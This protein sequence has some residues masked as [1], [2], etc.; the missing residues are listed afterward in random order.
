M[1]SKIIQLQN[2]KAELMER[3]GEIAKEKVYIDSFL[4]EKEGKSLFN[5]SEE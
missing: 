3:L 5:F 4:E 2:K 1:T